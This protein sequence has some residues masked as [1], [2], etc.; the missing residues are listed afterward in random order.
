VGES[1]MYVIE[2]ND[3]RWKWISGIFK[4][5]QEFEEYYNQ[6]PK[7]LQSSQTIKKLNITEYPF[8]IV[9]KQDGFTYLNKNDF[10]EML[11]NIEMKVENEHIVYFNFYYI[12]SDYQPKKSGTDYMGILKHD[13]V[14]N[15]FL[16][17]Y[18]RDGENYLRRNRFCE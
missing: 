7:D 18:K 10:L 17:F 12:E 8:Y 6:I 16:V 2:V 4:E 11:N 5:I 15:D 13:H 3:N 1:W 9:E 14:T